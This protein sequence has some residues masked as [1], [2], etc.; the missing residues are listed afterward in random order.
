MSELND[1]FW[2]P[3]LQDIEEMAY[4]L[5]GCMCPNLM[6]L[7]GEIGKKHPNHPLDLTKTN[8]ETYMAML[9]FA[10][11]LLIKIRE[12]NIKK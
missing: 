1:F 8:V 6:N 11:H 2:N 10:N 9:N 3:S 4:D 5:Y 7:L 12:N